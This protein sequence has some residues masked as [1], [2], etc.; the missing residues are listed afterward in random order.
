M[1]SSN[2]PRCADP[3]LQEFVYKEDIFEA[4]EIWAIYESTTV[5]ISLILG[6]KGNSASENTF[7]SE[8]Y[9]S[10]GTS[11][12]GY[13][14]RPC[15]VLD[16]GSGEPDPSQG[17]QICLMTTFHKTQ[18]IEDLPEIC[19]RFCFPVSSVTVSRAN[20]VHFHT[21]P[22]WTWDTSWIIVWVYRTHSELNGRWQNRESTNARSAYK[23]DDQMRSELLRLARQCRREWDAFCR[24]SRGARKRCS[25]EY[26]AKIRELRAER[27]AKGTDEQQVPSQPT[28]PVSAHGLYPILEDGGVVESTRVVLPAQ[29]SNAP[30]NAIL[31]NTDDAATVDT[32]DGQNSGNGSDLPGQP[33][34]TPIGV[35]HVSFILVWTRVA[36]VY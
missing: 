31:T 35:H 15:I 34:A 27:E 20:M 6:Y 7:F 1:T 3:C 24:S 33:T 28:S 16:R 12:D 17:Y 4:G 36:S 18:K 19:Q 11:N 21:T 13:K 29:A 8:S 23:F 9:R 32:A 26:W 30:T 2:C 10:P 5:P 25:K 14:P 22:E